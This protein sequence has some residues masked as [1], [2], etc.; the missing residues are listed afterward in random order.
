MIDDMSGCISD[1]NVHK[2]LKTPLEWLIWSSFV[3]FYI[4]L[5]LDIICMQEE[6]YS[7]FNWYEC[8]FIGIINV[9]VRNSPALICRFMPNAVHHF[10]VY[11]SHNRLQ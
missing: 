7:N 10:V 3:L 11:E 8:K 1:L 9:I 2:S 5:S 4:F 6:V